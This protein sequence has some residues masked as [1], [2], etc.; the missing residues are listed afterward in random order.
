MWMP[1]D[2]LGAEIAAGRRRS[3]D[4]VDAAIAA[5]EEVNPQLNAVVATRYAEARAEAKRA[6]A[7][8]AR[9]EVLGPLH[10]VPCT[11]KEAFAVT[12]MPWTTGHVA[13]RGTRAPFDAPSVTR[14][15]Q[16]GAIVLGVTNTSELCMWM[17]SRNPVYGQTS[18][19]YDTG[20]TA[21][22]SSGGEG[23]I[24]GSGASPF[25]LGS[26]VGGSIRMPAFFNG[27][28]GLKP[29][30]GLVSNDGQFPGAEGPDAYLLATGPLARRARDVWT[31][32]RVLSGGAVA[33]DPADVRLAGLTVLDVPQLGRTPVAA[34]LRAVQVAAADVLG[35]AGMKVT[36]R[37]FPRFSAALD[38]WSASMGRMGG[39][40]A[41]RKLLGGIRRRDA[42][43]HLL[44]P[45]ELGGTVTLPSAVLALVEDVGTASSSRQARLLTDLD[46]LRREVLDALDGG[47]MLFP[48]HPLPAPRHGEPLLRPL[49]WTYTALFNALGLPVF[50]VPLGLDAA[51]LPLGV[52]VVGAPGSDALLVA[53]GE[54]LEGA[55]GGWVAPP[56]APTGLDGWA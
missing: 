15:Q 6:D 47:V 42:L 8:A 40:G 1:V 38:L 37:R 28:F 55:F 56:V 36:P 11:I 5:I 2:A 52:Q 26:D 25:G 21:G 10:G 44:W 43:R 35:R 4:A 49:S 18:N 32:T 13:R 54:V 20:R 17:E 29:S 14:L 3:A 39:A 53:V 33:G 45:A 30:P 24:V 50:Q 34:S 16:A 46:H 23:A 22:G 7:A 27:V 19:P 12:G 31:L 48:S 9:G 41:Y 51:G